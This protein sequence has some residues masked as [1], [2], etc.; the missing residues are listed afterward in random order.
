MGTTSKASWEILGASIH[1]GVIG[2][3][4]IIDVTSRPS[5]IVLQCYYTVTV[6][7]Y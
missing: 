6:Y 1:Q 3:M 5:I 4:I 7:V 2:V